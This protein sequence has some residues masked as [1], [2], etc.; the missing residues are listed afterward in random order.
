MTIHD[1]QSFVIGELTALLRRI[2]P[3][4]TGAAYTESNTRAHIVVSYKDKPAETIDVTR[5]D[6]IGIAVSGILNSRSSG[7]NK[8]VKLWRDRL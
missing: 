2:D 6:L 7:E 5:C 3:A 1:K 8:L 4:I